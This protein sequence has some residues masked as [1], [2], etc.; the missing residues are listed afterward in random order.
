MN[1]NINLFHISEENDIEVFEP[2]KPV[3]PDMQNSPAFVWA[4]NEAC[5][6]NYLMPRDCPRV[7]FHVNESTTKA[8]KRK[9]LSSVSDHV[10]AIESRWFEK[11]KNTT[12]Y[13]YEFDSA[14]FYL[15]DEIAGYYVSEKTQNPISKMILTDLFEEL[16]RR[17]IELRILPE[18]ITLRDEII[19]TSFA[20]S[21]CR[22][23]NAIGK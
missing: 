1:G 7:A 20:W 10:I 3:R 16:F 12:L 2:R 18:I 17:N 23:V 11:M 13:L 15:Q 6:P 8:D 22:M 9:H 19:N 4:I 14:D 21:M 5:L